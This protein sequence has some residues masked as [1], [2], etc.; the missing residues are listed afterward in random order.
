MFTLQASNRTLVTVTLSSR[1]RLGL[2]LHK[3]SSVQKMGDI[4]LNSEMI[5]LLGQ[6]L[7]RANTEIHELR[8]NTRA[9]S[10]VRSVLLLLAWTC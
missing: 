6:E 3:P 4:T 5:K 1:S 2:H 7:R 8:Q 10:T 9:A